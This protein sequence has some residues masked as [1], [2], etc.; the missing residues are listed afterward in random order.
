MSTQRADLRS[1]WV[2]QQ[3]IWSAYL[4]SSSLASGVAGWMSL[5]V[6]L[7]LMRSMSDLHKLC[8]RQTVFE[9]RGK[10]P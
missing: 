3:A 1:S 5:P 8:G 9:Q 2:E 10:V 4:R 6:S 7:E